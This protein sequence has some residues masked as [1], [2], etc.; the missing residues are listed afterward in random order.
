MNLSLTLDT[1]ADAAYVRASD[2]KVARTEKKDS[3]RLIDLADDGKIVG[4]EFLSVS[5]GVEL[6]GLPWR[7]EITHLFEDCNIKV[8]A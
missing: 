2:D 3:Q 8:F 6:E 7:E 1:S 5:K 4:F